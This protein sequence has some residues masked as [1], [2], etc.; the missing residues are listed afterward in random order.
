MGLL[1]TGHRAL[2]KLASSIQRTRSFRDYVSRSFLTDRILKWAVRSKQG[3]ESASLTDSL[4]HQS[5]E[6]IRERELWVPVAGLYLEEPIDFG[7]ATLVT[8]PRSSLDELERSLADL[9]DPDQRTAMARWIEKSRNKLQGLGGVS[10]RLT[11][12]P[13]RAEELVLEI[14]ETVIGLLRFFSSANKLPTEISHLAPLG[15]E[16]AQSVS[17]YSFE[18][19]KL[20]TASSSVVHKG[21]RSILDAKSIKAIRSSGLDSLAAVLK[22]DSRSDFEDVVIRTLLMFSRG[23]LTVDLS[24]RLVFQ[25]A[26]LESLLLRNSTEPIQHVMS[27]R[28]AFFATTDPDAR[29]RIIR[30]VK[31]AYELRSKFLHHGKDPTKEETTAVARFS[32]NS[33]RFLLRVV[34]KISSY[35]SGDDFISAI[36]DHK[37][38]DPKIGW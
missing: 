6:A 25:F 18:N 5:H 32:H 12:E 26:A 34:E 36:E 16:P 20:V 24:Q 8:F 31:D 37:L 4:R 28:M 38:G 17:V 9:T 3:L 13:R 33:W 1:D 35:N 23:A 21:G 10:V 2:S 30:S 27:E 7:V 22:K 29:K 11:A 14:A 19:E 15:M